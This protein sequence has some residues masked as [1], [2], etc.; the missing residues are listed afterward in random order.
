MEFQVITSIRGCIS[1]SGKYEKK[2]TDL[3]FLRRCVVEQFSVHLLCFRRSN[4]PCMGCCRSPV[5]QGPYRAYKLCFQLL[6]Q[7]TVK[8]DS[9]RFVRR[10]SS[11]LGCQNRQVPACSS[12]T[13][14]SGYGRAV[15]QRRHADR[16]VQVSLPCRAS[17]KSVTSSLFA[18]SMDS[19]ESGIPQQVISFSM[20][21]IQICRLCGLSLENARGFFAGQCMKSLIDDDNP[22][23]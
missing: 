8:F 20:S 12:S 17:H 15:Q 6:F 1:T 19:A 22:P 21:K 3:N 18:A 10:D 4:H 13:F 7:S 9:L 11:N 16:I 2:Y 14:R 5:S 23:V